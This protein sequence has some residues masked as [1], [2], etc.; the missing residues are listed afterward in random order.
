MTNWKKTQ[1]WQKL[2]KFKNDEADKVK[3]FL[4]GQNCMNKIE[5]IL[6]SGETSPK[7]F[8]LHD[9][10]H[11]FRV[12]ERMWEIIPPTTQAILSEYELAFLLLSAYLHDIGMT[13][14]IKKVKNH[15]LCLNT[16]EKSV[17]SIL[18][19][20]N[21]QK[22]LD[23]EGEN[24]DLEKGNLNNEDK[25]A[26]LVTFYCRHRHNDWSE[27]WIRNNFKDTEFGHYTNWLND[28]VNICISHHYGFEELKSEKFNPLRIHGR[29]IHKRYI[30]MCLR[31]ADV[32]EI[33]PERAPEVLIKHRNIIEGSISHW[34]KEKFTSVSIENNCIVVTA[35]PTK[36]FIHKAISDIADQIE[37]ETNLCNTLNGEIPLRNIAPSNDLKHEW[38]I[39]PSIY[40][41]IKETGNY[42]FIDGTFKPNS[43]KLLQLL[44]GTEL[45]GNPILAIR[46]IVQN[47]LDA[48]KV[49]MAYKILED[50]IK[51]E[52]ELQKLEAKFNIN[53]TVTL[54]DEEYWITCQDNGVGMDK[55]VLKK[56][57]LVGGATKRHELLELERKCKKKGH[58]LEITGQ[59][60][61][62]V[63][64]YFMIADKMIIKTNKSFQSGNQD[65][66]GWEFEING[67]S[68]FGELRKT[69]LKSNGTTVKL[70]LKKELAT[71]LQNSRK[72]STLIESTLNR[73]PCNFSLT[74]LGDVVI[75]YSPGWCKPSSFFKEK[76]IQ[77][78]GES[79]KP[80]IKT[81]H[82]FISE[83]Q[84]SVMD[85]SNKRKLD[86]HDSFTKSIEFLSDEG[87]L[88]NNNGY[89]RI[90]VPVF[91]N[92]KGDSFGFF[93]EKIE[94]GNIILQ[95]IN[96]GFL[97]YPNIENPSISWKG[98]AINSTQQY[99]RNFSYNNCIIEL[100]LINEKSFDISVSRLEISYKS[101]FKN[102][103]GEIETKI[104]DLLTLNKKRFQNSPYTFFNHTI[105]NEISLTNK[106]LFWTYESGYS[107]DVIKFEQIKF[108]L[109]VDISTDI[110]NPEAELFKGKSFH[111]LEYLSSC[112]SGYSGSSFHIKKHKYKLDKAIF[113]NYYN[114]R[115]SFLISSSFKENDKYSFIGNACQFPPE[116]KEL[117]CFRG[118]HNYDIILNENSPYFR[119]VNKPDFLFAQ[120]IFEGRISLN[121]TDGDKILKSKKKS[122]CFMTYLISLNEKDYWDGVVKNNPEFIKKIWHK[123]FGN[124]EDIIYFF[125]DGISDTQLIA[126]TIESWTIIKNISEIKKQLPIPNSEWRI[127]EKNKS[128]HPTRG[129]K[130]LRG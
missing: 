26:E 72:I 2:S 32:I 3:A 62:G 92:E 114:Y 52:A 40:R 98:I 41:G 21:F 121:G 66:N 30:A 88:D 20:Y 115:I 11:S 70:R 103:L 91:K 50:D 112:G 33:D 86:T 8:T 19:K 35:N 119:Y 71:Q 29:V 80:E 69:E 101:K 79:T 5:Q 120:N 127:E 68:D 58:N 107:K 95:K 10:D 46:E 31:L 39:L 108:P 49:Q 85:I 13:P 129:H 94:K 38:N 124:I 44:A 102:I 60:G 1:V 57:F 84:L 118:Y 51:T 97:F 67:L 122:F 9:A 93:F 78:F 24:I 90:H 87:K 81:S 111:R 4:L 27:E 42:E 82:D 106:N 113:H 110:G 55:E 123:M 74:T 64:S 128:Q 28:L 65:G 130:T 105:A 76:L 75:S 96:K 116:W 59:F 56:C 45:Y 63:L 6:K 14:E 15:Y 23:D 7:D 109:I 126:I 125:H 12:A 77:Q 99:G 89:Y 47:S 61:I 83:E 34:L 36:A 37:H 53:L 16:T 54:E 104:I 48:I 43:K 73:I 117:F 18:E 22:W 25:A 100:D 17:L